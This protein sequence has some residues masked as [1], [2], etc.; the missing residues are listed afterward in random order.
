MPE[1]IRAHHQQSSITIHTLVIQNT[2]QHPLL[3]SATDNRH[4]LLKT[5]DY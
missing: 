4:F 5:L 1:A 2:R 3:Q